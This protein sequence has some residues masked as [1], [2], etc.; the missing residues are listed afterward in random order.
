MELALQLAPAVGLEHRTVGGRGAVE[1][2][3]LAHEIPPAAIS[4]S[5]SRGT[6]NP[7]AV[8]SKSRCDRLAGAALQRWHRHLAQ[9]ALG[10]EAVAKQPV[11]DLACGLSH[12]RAHGREHD[13]RLPCGFGPGL[14][15]GV[16]SVCE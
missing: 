11:G 2:D 1:A 10:A 13:L 7:G 6:M 8:I 16:I 3:L 14:K 15:N 4:S 12:E 5:L 9:V